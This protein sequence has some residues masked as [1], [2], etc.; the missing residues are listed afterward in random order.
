[1]SKTN[2]KPSLKY[3]KLVENA[4]VNEIIQKV[5]KRLTWGEAMNYQ[6]A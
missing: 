6:I 5:L 2:G 1:M 4:V 3:N